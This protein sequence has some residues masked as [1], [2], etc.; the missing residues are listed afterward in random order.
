MAAAEQAGEQGFPSPHG[1]PARPALA[2]GVVVDQALIPLEGIPADITLMVVADQ[3][4]PLR[5]LDPKTARD[6][7]SAILDSRLADRPAVR[8]G[9]GVNRVGE[10]VMDRVVDGRLPLQTPA[11]R[12]VADGG[13][14]DP[15]LPKPEMD[16]PHALQFDEL[17]EDQGKRLAHAKVWIL[18]DLIGS[19]AHI[20]NRDCRE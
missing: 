15:L 19:A 7:L 3:N 16:L 11:F 9:A 10:D 4:V 12:A 2:V 18:L 17:A 20:A 1:A 13:Q 6:A 5:P 14:H 8:I